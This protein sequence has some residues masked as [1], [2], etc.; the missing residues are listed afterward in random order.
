MKLIQCLFCLCLVGQMGCDS[1]TDS[2][3]RTDFA[4][5]RLK[6]P[7]LTASQV[8]DQSLES[9]V[10]AENPF[11]ATNDLRSY[12]WQTHEFSVTATVDSQL[13][14]LRRTLGPTGGIP[15][16]VTVGTDR[17]YVG[18]FWYGYSSLI[19]QVPFIDAIG[20]PHRINK[21]QSV[22]VSEDKRNDA[23]IYRALKGAGILIE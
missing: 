15:F 16:V 17:I 13:V 23:R 22:L 9:L 7:N 21:C 18:A 6:D 2:G 10:L 8:W 20:D 14:L 19:P 4:I 1:G 12:R 11:L 5:Y 3:Q